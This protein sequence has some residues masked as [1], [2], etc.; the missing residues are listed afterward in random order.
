M[1]ITRLIVFLILLPL[2]LFAQSVPPL[3]NYQGQL[4]NPDGSPLA[5]ANYQLTLK[6]Y[7]AASGGNLVWGPEIFD[8][9]AGLG[10]GAMIPLV[11]G[12]FNVILGPSDTSGNSLG[13]AFNA[14]NRFIEVTV[15]NNP[16]I[17]PR[18][19]ILTTPFAFQ[20]GSAANT[21]L[22]SNV[23]SGI[24]IT[25]AV[26]ANSVFGG[27]GGGLTS[28][29]ANN[30]SSG[31]VPLARLS[32]ITS[33][34]F[35]PAT[36]QLAT[37]LN[38]GNAALASNLVTGINI[39][40]AFLTN[41]VFGGNGGGLTNL[42][43]SQL[44]GGVIPPAQLPSIVVTN[45][46][47]GV[48]LT[49]AFSGN[50]SGLTSLNANNLF[51]GTVPLAQLGGITSNQLDPATW[52][53]ATN[54]NGGNAALASNVVSGINLT[55]AFLTN[56][57]L[58]NSVF[59]GNG[60]GLT[61]LN[62]S[63]LAGGVIPLAQLPGVLGTLTITNLSVSNLSLPGPAAAIYSGP[64]LLLRADGMQNFF[65][66][67][68]AGNVTMTGGN[69]TANGYEALFNNTSGSYNTASG[70]ETLFNNTNGL[71]NTAIGAEALYFNT[72]GSYNTASGVQALQANTTGSQ[73]TAS[74]VYAMFN[75]TTGANN[76]ASG[77]QALSANI[78]GND[79][80]ASGFQALDSNTNGYDNVASGYRALYLNTSGYENTAS[81][82]EALYSN[83]TGYFNTAT[84][85]EALYSNTSG[86]RNTA[87]GLEAL[88]GNTTGTDNTASG[89]ESLHSNT[90]GQ[91][92]TADGAD[93][94]YNNTNGYDNTA[95]GYEALYSNTSGYE[96][97]ATGLE[98][99]F[100]NTSGNDNTAAGLEALYSN[101]NGDGNTA[102]GHY[103]LY[104]NTTGSYN[105]ASG[106]NALYSNTNGNF[107]VAFG[108][109]AGYAITTGS[110][111]IDIGNEGA[112]ADNNIIRL[113]VQGTQTNAFIAGISGATAAGGVA[114]YVTAGGQLGT[115]TSSARFKTN[116]SSMADASEVLL[117]LHPVTFRYRP[118]I[119]PQHLPQFG[120]VAEEV[121][122]VDPDLVARDDKN[123]IYTVRYEAVNAMLLNEFL[124]EHR[125]VEEQTGEIHD[126][127][128][129]LDA[130]EKVV[131][132]KKSN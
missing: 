28:L 41:S 102:S 33:N 124:K 64:N 61:N 51:I 95:S 29:N 79:N 127:Q 70:L 86:F 100:L 34:Q 46:E 132:G 11:Q 7:D 54:L 26:I 105:T 65:T 1:K 20:A 92:N 78:T 2:Q 48:T 66:G 118:E 83:M 53:L 37:N 32:G 3:V 40:N 4:S 72:S 38:G 85:L 129:R 75:N 110:N 50:G 77:F 22:A 104:S 56:A 27:N 30:L 55:N 131:L 73:N 106:Y 68:N 44:A 49:G 71:Q 97:T 52:Q 63:Q 15:S 47:T 42:N 84:G 113:G 88:F 69:N 107:N 8:G 96:N 5:T 116:I 89:I 17:A 16:P 117:S 80:T 18:Q 114:V 125:K 91:N 94:L 99:L 59:G 23:V 10:H 109:A 60:G 19:Q 36:W 21:A 35:D 57:V 62:A 123:Q 39:T 6:V 101:T 12:Y 122:K 108:Y 45:T 128:E 31:T 90:T 76:T 81:G 103:A 87:S 130:L 25:N 119:D 67:P 93:A 14:T 13:G 121:D 58:T 24:S 120:L 43:A 98:A 74:G 9:N 115:L 111:N 126:L 112:A 82:F